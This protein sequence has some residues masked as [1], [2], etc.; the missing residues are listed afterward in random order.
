MKIVEKL[1]RKI[2]SYLADND[3]V[4]DQQLKTLAKKI[5]D[6]EFEFNEQLYKDLDKDILF[7]QIM[8][9]IYWQKSIKIGNTTIIQDKISK[10]WVFQRREAGTLKLDNWELYKDHMLDL[11]RKSF[12]VLDTSTDLILDRS[13]NP[14]EE[15]PWTRRGLVM[16]SVQ[17]GK[18]A[19]YL[20]LI[21]KASDAGYKI[22]IVLSGIHNLLRQQTQERLDEGYGGKATIGKNFRQPDDKYIGV[23][24]F[25]RQLD[26]PVFPKAYTT[27]ESDFNKMMQNYPS[28]HELKNPIY[29]V[30]KKNSKVLEAV[31]NWLE[32][33]IDNNRGI[34][35][36]LLLLDDEA[37]NASI[38]TSQKKDEVTKINRSI[39]TILKLF[40]RRTYIGY[41]A[42]PFANIFIDPD[43]E[44]FNEILDDSPTTED[45]LFPANFIIQL[46][47]SNAYN[48]P[49]KFFGVEKDEK[50]VTVIDSDEDGAED[51]ERMIPYRHKKDFKITELSKSLEH[52]IRTFIL[53]K[54]LRLSRGQ[55]GENHSMLVNVTFYVG[56]HEDL[57]AII[58][59]YV[60]KINR[61]CISYA[62][63]SPEKALENI[64]IEDLRKSFVKEFK[65]KDENLS[66]N[67]D[68]IFPHIQAAST[69]EVLAINGSSKDFLS[70]DEREYP[71]G[72][73]LIAIGG[74]SLSRGFTLKGLSVSYFTRNTKVSDTLLQMARWF[75]YRENYEDLCR[76]FITTS[77]NTYYSQITQTIGELN[78][79]IK[80]MERL[81]KT[82]KEFG[83]KVREHPGGLE[84]T[85]RN[86]IGTG[87]EEVRSLSFWG[88]KHQKVRLFQDKTQNNYNL[89]LLEKLIVEVENSSEQRQDWNLDKGNFWVN[90]PSTSVRTF[91]D[92]FQAPS[93]IKDKLLVD[94]LKRLE[95]EEVFLNKWN[96]WFFSLQNGEEKAFDNIKVKPRKRTKGITLSQGEIIFNNSNIGDSKDDADLLPE[97]VSLRVNEEY[98]RDNPDKKNTPDHAYRSKLD[99]PTL[100]VHPLVIDNNQVDHEPFSLTYTVHFPVV[101]DDT[102]DIKVSY[103][104]NKIEQI[105]EPQDF[106][107]EESFDE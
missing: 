45:D 79:E 15:G 41:T 61:A 22:I 77:A 86:K 3:S 84:V 38:N 11:D 66:I 98:L 21:N 43:E 32:D 12:N 102:R 63:L 1:H 94:F 68:D 67:F 92:G 64:H 19:N 72:R 24:E 13:G 28:I 54:A 8:G 26:D 6:L 74:H 49:E 83:L 105:V 46:D 103:L 70:Y 76:L 25:R 80:E 2:N 97:E 99:N 47:P 52:A 65:D 56:I 55:A 16:G 58:H 107:D 100:I 88:K 31:V 53:V 5:I 48:G 60:S 20:G 57:K 69:I 101:D 104:T 87:K 106:G 91:I 17:S 90:V 35:E 50:L 73:T 81:G 23:G 96:F 78:D 4:N 71:N 42:T 85:A 14:F 27:S 95:S 82:P 51:L 44:Q 34:N 39:R 7:N 29:M 59:D 33:N 62:Q 9:K 18:T 30:L 93:D 75:G 10:P 89:D 36:P 40:N 37:D